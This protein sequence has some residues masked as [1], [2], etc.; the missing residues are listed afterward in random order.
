VKYCCYGTP[1]VI[2]TGRAAI[3]KSRRRSIRSH[4][5]A[6]DQVM[7]ITGIYILTSEYPTDEA[8]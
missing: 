4:V 6:S 5:R 2:S 3:D 1:V 8:A 7:I